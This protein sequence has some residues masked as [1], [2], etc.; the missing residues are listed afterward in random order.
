MSQAIEKIPGVPQLGK[1]LAK[2]TGGRGGSVQ[3]KPLLS[4]WAKAQAM[5]MYAQEHNEKWVHNGFLQ[6]SFTFDV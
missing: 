2:G 4:G 1:L 5:M 6:V 3:G